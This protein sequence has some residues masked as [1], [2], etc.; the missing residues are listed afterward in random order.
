MASFG[1]P[2][3]F[4]T[5]PTHLQPST[6]P[7][8]L[9][10]LY[11]RHVFL[12]YVPTVTHIPCHIIFNYFIIHHLLLYNRYFPRAG[13]HPVEAACLCIPS[14][15]YSVTQNWCS[16]SICSMNIWHI[17]YLEKTGKGI[18]INT[19]LS[20]RRITLNTECLLYIIIW[21]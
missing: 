15:Q 16:T 10:Y 1:K 3:W 4:A 17:F 6:R 12:L 20:L 21:W 5:H 14:T 2:T 11:Q 18:E 7:P 13:M 8:N 19:P 9:A